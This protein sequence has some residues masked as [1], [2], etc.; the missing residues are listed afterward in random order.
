[1]GYCCDGTAFCGTGSEYGLYGGLDGGGKVFGWGYC[2]DGT[3]FCG[4]DGLNGEVDGRGYC[5]YWDC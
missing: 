2:C 5:A 3:P 4:G 1:V